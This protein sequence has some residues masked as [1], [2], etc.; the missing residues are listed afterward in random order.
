VVLAPP[1]PIVNQPVARTGARL[2]IIDPDDRVLLIEEAWSEGLAAPWRHWLTPGGGVETGESLP[3]AASREVIE[4][5]GL[6]IELPADASAVLEHRRQWSWGDV[7]YDQLDHYFAARVARAFLAV[8]AAATAME[9]QTVVGSRWWSV[10]ELRASAAVFVPPMIAD[11]LADLVAA[12]TLSRPVGRVAGRVLVLDSVGRVLLLHTRQSVGGERT[13]WVAPGGGVEAG[14]SVL[15]A[16]ARE[17][18]EETGILAT[19]APGTPIA[20]MERAVFRVGDWHLDQTDHYV[21]HRLSSSAD[22]V[23]LDRSR[24]TAIEQATVLGWRWWSAAE[25]RATSELFWP[26]DLPAVLERLN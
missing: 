23:D 9:T 24:W 19:F 16:A 2:L 26:A 5:T 17:L 15:D 11:V 8:P 22:L 3:L 18:F 7:V 25:L 20:T 13:N 4:E 21:V 14:E 1:Y 6:R 10:A 12:D